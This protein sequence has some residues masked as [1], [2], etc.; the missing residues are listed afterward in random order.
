[1]AG[2][3][4]VATRAAPGLRITWVGH[5]TV[6]VELDGVRLLTDP[7]LRNRLTVLLPRVSGPADV[8]ALGRIDA[9]LVS[10]LHYDHLDLR[11]LD[12]LGPLPVVAPAGGARLLRK[13]GHEVTELAVGDRTRIG[14]VE[15]A[16]TE[17][18]HPG[19]RAPW[20]RDDAE[21]VGFMLSGS[22][23]VYFAGDTDLFDGM[24]TLAPG[25]DVALLPI[26]GW[27]ARVPA[28]HLD[29]LR[30]AQ[31]LRRLRPRIAV[32]IHWG[33]YRRVDMR[34]RDELLRAPANEFAKLAREHAPDVDVRILSVGESLDVPVSS[35]V[36]AEP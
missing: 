25:L 12:L 2:N 36:G 14:A 5:S 34:R 7:V 20:H 8:A 10:H 3:D 29:P 4:G 1:M 35:P 17:A 21:A 28:G 9:L 32:P 16:A 24:D 33:T 23:R 26:S 13:R 27:G 22:R 18:V 11:S 6:L 31:A 30:A 19:R 15:I